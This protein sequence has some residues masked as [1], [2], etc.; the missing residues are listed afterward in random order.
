MVADAPCSVLVQG[1]Y[2]ASEEAMA[3]GELSSVALGTRRV[4][5]DL[6]EGSG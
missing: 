4:R 1:R 3:S 2:S 5:E 6:M